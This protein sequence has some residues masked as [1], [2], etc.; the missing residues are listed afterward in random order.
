M[1][2]RLHKLLALSFP[3]LVLLVQAA[4][5]LPPTRLSLKRRGYSAT[6]RTL[7]RLAR[8]RAR[9]TLLGDDEA[10]AAA[11]ARLVYAAGARFPFRATCL[12]KALVLRTLLLRQGLAGELRI[13]VRIAGGRLEGHAWVE[14]EGVPLAQHPDV[15][16]YFKPFPGDLAA[17]GEW[18]G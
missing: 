12:P 14:H 13:G 2:G 3:E 15:A 6:M 16:E 7:D 8:R 9:V 1:A 10:R 11:V 17:V 18:V 5:T 4:V